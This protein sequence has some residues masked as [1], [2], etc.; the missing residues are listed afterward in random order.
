M[1]T[2]PCCDT[3]PAALTTEANVMLSMLMRQ[4]RLNKQEKKSK[5]PRVMEGWS[6]STG[7]NLQGHKLFY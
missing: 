4:V 2:D 6:C 1:I 7:S 5:L 3:E